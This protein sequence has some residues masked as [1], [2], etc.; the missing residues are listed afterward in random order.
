MVRRLTFG[1]A[2]DDLRLEW[3]S[4]RTLRSWERHSARVG[5]RPL[6]PIARDRPIERVAFD[7]AEARFAAGLLERADVDFLVGVAA[8]DMRDVVPDN[9]AIDVVGA[10]LEHELGHRERLHDPEGLDVR[11]VVEHEARDRKRAEVLESGRAGEVLEFASV[12]EE[13]E[14]DDG[15]VVAVGK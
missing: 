6:L 8:A 11:E 14:G 7:G 4:R 10:V 12:G 1:G 2:S 13:G 15:L 5:D 9:G 3:I